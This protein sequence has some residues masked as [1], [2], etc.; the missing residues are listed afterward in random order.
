MQPW[1]LYLAVVV[2]LLVVL[3]FAVAFFSLCGL[4]QA[5][6][7]RGSTTK[8]GGAVGAPTTSPG[9]LAGCAAV[10]LH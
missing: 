9:S 6:K 1:R 2:A 10:G 5:A 3:A 8:R 7:E 4:A